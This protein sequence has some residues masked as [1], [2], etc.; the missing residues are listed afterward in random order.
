MAE[1][2]RQTNVTDIDIEEEMR[3]SF[4]TFAMSVIIARALPD[5]RDGLKPAQRRILYAMHDLNLTPGAQ[6]RKCAKIAGDTQGNYHPHGQEVIYPTLAR[7]AQD[8]NMRY[9]LVDG[10]GNFGSVDGDPPAAMRYTEARLSV[11]GAEMLADLDRETVDLLPNYDQTREEPVV[12]PGRFPNLLCNG[13]SGIAVG[14]ATSIPPHNLSEVVDACVLMIDDPE[15]TVE[16]I[17]EVLPGPDFPTGALILGSAGVRQAYETGRG[18]ITMQARASIEPLEGG[19]TAILITEIPYQVNKAQL[20]EQIADLVKSKRLQD[21]SGLRDE[22]DRKG[23]RIVVELKREANPHVVLN[24]LY[25]HTRMRTSFPVNSVALI[26]DFGAQKPGEPVPLVPR[27][28]GIRE[29]ISHF[30]DHR[31]EVVVFRSQHD[32]ARAQARAHIL[33]GYRIALKN[34]DEII[35]I[36]RRS[37]SPPAAREELMA[38]FSLSERQAQAIL[39]LMLQRLTS[40]ER[41]K[42]DEE[43]RETIKTIGQLE[44]VLGKHLAEMV[45]REDRVQA[46]REWLHAHPWQPRKVMQIVR[47][48]LLDLKA[49]RGDARRTEIRPEEAGDISIED[50]IAD[51][52]MVITMTRDGYIKRL[53]VATYRTQGRGGKGVIGLTRKEEDAVEHLFVASTHTTILFFTNRG[54]A[55]RLRAHEIPLASRQARGTAVINLIPIE[56]GERVTVAR[57]VRRFASDRYLLMATRRGMVKKTALSEYDTRLKGGII[58]VNLH[59]DDELEWVAETD[60]KQDIVLATER[61]QAIRFSEKEVRPMGRAAGGVRGIRLRKDDRVIGM[62]VV[63]QGADLLVA[64]AHGY[65]KRTA[66]DE[67]RVQGRGGIGI[68][69]LSITKRNGPMVGMRIVDENDDLLIITTAGQIIRQRVADIRRIGRSTQGVRLIRLEEGDRVASIARVVRRDIEEE[70]E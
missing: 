29:L 62:G 40:L 22:S 44:D 15:V 7:L 34:L 35:Q 45:G 3:D 39:E 19:R 38:R 51:E 16:Q 17:M 41:Q 30:L 8:W 46:T 21:V 31:R 25:K 28:L 55:Y 2:E 27:T 12:L 43:Y 20:V 14:M 61:G 68:R 59:E 52:D 49:R 9:P 10:H 18:S 23:M 50:L 67:Y 36:I 5:V 56:P 13:A 69:T 57:A 48:E 6:H 60:G 64:T 53:P 66:L 26:A 63:R 32:L 58:A 4:M 54:K 33:E 11:Y 37:E 65:G 24:T 42:I 47:D 1:P 70:D